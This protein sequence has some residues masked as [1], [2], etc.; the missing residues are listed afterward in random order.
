MALRHTTETQ[1]KPSSSEEFQMWAA[2]VGQS[3]RRVDVSHDGLGEGQDWF[4]DSVE[5]NIPQMGKNYIFKV[6]LKY[7]CQ[8]DSHLP[9]F[10]LQVFAF[11]AQPIFPF[12]PA[13]GVFDAW[14][15]TKCSESCCYI[16]FNYL[17]I[18]R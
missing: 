17:S 8:C 11:Q 4:I 1:F 14:S 13:L 5:V 12:Q 6:R 16:V 9:N 2:R 18:C 15:F 3:V 7:T 10:N